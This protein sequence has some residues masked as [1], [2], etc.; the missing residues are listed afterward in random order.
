MKGTVIMNFLKSRKEKFFMFHLQSHSEVRIPDIPKKV[1]AKLP[2][3]LTK[4]HAIKIYGRVE[5]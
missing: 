1:K 4:H 3:C 2:P 5:V